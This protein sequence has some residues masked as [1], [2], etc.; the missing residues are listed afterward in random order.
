[1][2]DHVLG[3]YSFLIAGILLWIVIAYSLFQVQSLPLWLRGI[4]A[5]IAGGLMVGLWM[6]LRPTTSP[7]VSDVSDAQ[8]LIGAG[9]PTML[10]FY[11]EY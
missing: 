11:S 8:N 10:E 3:S 4:G 1:L 5:I 6:I 9:K 2:E 7:G